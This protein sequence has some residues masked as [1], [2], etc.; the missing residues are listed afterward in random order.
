MCALLA[1]FEEDYTVMNGQQDTKYFL[2]TYL[3]T[4]CSRVVL[5]KLTGL[6]PVKKFPAFYG[7]QRAFTVFTSARHLSL[8]WA[9]SSQYIP[10]HTTSW[11]GILILSSHLRLGLPSDLFS[12]G[13][14]TKTVCTPLQFPIHATCSA[15]LI[16]N[17]NNNINNTYL[18][19]GAESFL[20]GWLAC[21]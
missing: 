4:P 18:L 11:R 16:S 14:P 12:S 9:S 15:H 17:N 6:Q 3:L 8:S 2:F 19:H 13:F 5:Q 21:S 7:T 1:S 10:P 20:S